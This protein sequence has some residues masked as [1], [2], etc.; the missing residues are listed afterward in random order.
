MLRQQCTVYAPKT[1][2]PLT[3]LRDSL[4]TIYN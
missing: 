2:R 4:I 3:P 1:Q